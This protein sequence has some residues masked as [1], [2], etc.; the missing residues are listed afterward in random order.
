MITSPFLLLSSAL[1]TWKTNLKQSQ[2]CQAVSQR[3]ITTRVNVHNL[4]QAAK[5][6][7]LAKNVFGAAI[8]S[9]LSN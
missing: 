5:W 2:L 9:P 3:F 7:S 8:M 4:A 6:G 1:Q